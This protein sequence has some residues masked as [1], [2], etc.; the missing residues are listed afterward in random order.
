MAVPS[1]DTPPLFERLMLE[2]RS[3]PSQIT[4]ILEV[5]ILNGTMK[6]G[7]RLREAQLAEAFAVSR[8]TVREALRVLERKGLVRHI[9]HRGAEVMKLTEEDVADLYRARAVLER[10][11][12]AAAVGSEEAHARLLVEVEGIESANDA[13]DKRA[14]LKHD[15]SFHRTLVEQIGSRRLEEQYVTLQ[16][17]LTLALS[18]LDSYEPMFQVAEHR[19]IVD[20]LRKGRAEKADEVLKKHLGVAAER[21]TRMVAE[22][23]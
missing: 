3:T 21:L 4:D 19:M 8:N 10:A 16:R 6:P 12:A 15:F 13:D 14:L 5:E 23:G 7:E 1:Q 17:E 2:R 18:Q 22:Q 9:P 11:G 20:A